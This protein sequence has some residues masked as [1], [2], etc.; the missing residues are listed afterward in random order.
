MTEDLIR[1]VKEVKKAMVEKELTGEEWEE[2]KEAL[3][4]LEDVTSYLKDALGKGIEF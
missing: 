4:K 3:K 1:K 2:R